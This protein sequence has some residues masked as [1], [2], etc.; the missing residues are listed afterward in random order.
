MHS[1]TVPNGPLDLVAIFE[2]EHLVTVQVTD[3]GGTVTPPDGWWP[4]GSIVPIEAMPGPYHVFGSW[5]GSGPGS[6]TGSQNPASV[7]VSGPI[8]QVADFFRISQ[9]IALSLSATDPSVS[10]GAPIGFGAAYLWA[11][12]ST[13]GGVKSLDADLTGSMPVIGF[14]P[15]AGVFNA[16]SATSLRLVVTNCLTGPMLLGTVAVFDQAGGELCLAPSSQTGT[17]SATDC[18]TAGLVYEWPADVHVTGVRTDGGVP[19]AS[20]RGCGQDVAVA[21]SALGASAVSA[22]VAVQVAPATTRLES[23]RP[24]PSSGITTFRYS[25]ARPG[26][27]RLM[28]YDVAGRRVRE[29]KAG[30]ELAGAHA[31][32]WDGRDRSGRP[33]PAGV[34]L[35]RLTADDG[36]YTVKVVHTD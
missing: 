31:V 26:P 2:N 22:P 10:T 34:Y 21:A 29:L 6:F 20:G 7:T 32:Q 4:E 15:A 18:S 35:V 28:L 9:E 24:N 33:V 13:S 12:C 8:T 17:L 5:I 14:T 30:E 36:S 16:G 27:V 25:L 11:V 19:C 3:S 23:P 1:V